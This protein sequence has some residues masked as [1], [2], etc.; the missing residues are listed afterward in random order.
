MTWKTSPF[1]EL[2]PKP[3]VT[4]WVEWDLAQLV[5][6][7][8]EGSSKFLAT[9]PDPEYANPGAYVKNLIAYAEKLENDSRSPA[10]KFL[11][12]AGFPYMPAG[13]DPTTAAIKFAVA[14]FETLQSIAVNLGDTESASVYDAWVNHTGQYYG[15]HLPAAPVTVPSTNAATG[16]GS[17][18]GPSIL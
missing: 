2:P 7:D 10:A 18:V 12:D 4:S 11:M 6:N 17:V 14:C 1:Y 15:G 5:R 9:D 8:T 3:P 13:W 16:Q